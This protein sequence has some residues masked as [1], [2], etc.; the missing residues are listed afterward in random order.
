MND[1][2]K[3]KF[4]QEIKNLNTLNNSQLMEKLIEAMKVF[5]QNL[6]TKTPG[7]ES[8]IKAID[9]NKTAEEILQMLNTQEAIEQNNRL[10]VEIITELSYRNMPVNEIL[11]AIN[12][13]LTATEICQVF[14][15]KPDDFQGPKPNIPDISESM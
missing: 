13:G 1:P 15:I 9:E 10:V 12:K 2:E 14:E 5:D 6:K 3:E 8:I 4:F 11:A 7:I